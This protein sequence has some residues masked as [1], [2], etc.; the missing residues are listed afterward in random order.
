MARPVL[1][2]DIAAGGCF[3]ERQAVPIRVQHNDV[4]HAVAVCLRLFVG[5][6]VSGQT[7]QEIVE[8]GHT[9]RDHRPAQPLGSHGP[10]V[11]VDPRIL[12]DS[13]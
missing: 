10:I 6:P 1:V 11:D 4:T 9:E 7:S 13:P 5:Y 12:T 3:G 8:I 2:V